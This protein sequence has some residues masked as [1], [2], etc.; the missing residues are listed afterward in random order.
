MSFFFGLSLI[1][2]SSEATRTTP[3][4]QG[5]QAR[6]GEEGEGRNMRQN[7]SMKK[8]KEE[9]NRTRGGGTGG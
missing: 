5:R 7:R 9:G 6:G 4:G 3:L 1:P 8:N 2:L